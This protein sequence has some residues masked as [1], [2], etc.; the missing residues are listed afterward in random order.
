MV[1]VTS[2]L[3][4]L[5]I[6]ALALSVRVNVPKVIARL[7]ATAGSGPKLEP[8]NARSV[9]EAVLELGVHEDPL[10]QPRVVAV[11]KLTVSACAMLAIPT[12]RA[13]SRISFLIMRSIEPW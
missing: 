7:P 13:V 10:K 6:H 11:A 4:S 9:V 8:E 12:A 1:K 2:P 5:S 3:K